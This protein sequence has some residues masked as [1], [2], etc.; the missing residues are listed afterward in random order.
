MR[1]LK[2][3][4]EAFEALLTTVFP[5]TCQV[6]GQLVET[7]AN[8]SACQQ[9]WAELVPLIPTESCRRCAYPLKLAAGYLPT[10]D[11]AFCRSL[12]F[13]CARACGRYEG[14]L[15]ASILQLKCQP[16]ICKKLVAMLAK[17]FDCE[18]A[19]QASE[20]I[21]PV[22]L[23]IERLRERGFNQAEIIGEKLSQIINRPIDAASLIRIKPTTKHRTGMDAIDRQKSVANAFTVE[24]PRLI[25]DA[26]I[27][28]V[29]DLFTTGSTLSAC[30]QTLI[31]AGATRVNV[32]TLARVVERVNHEG[33][34][35]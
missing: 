31:D 34:E 6:C 23:H 20:I 29:D 3:I 11:C 7:G 32:L 8:G 28:L 18:P 13:H 9:C 14:A 25:K 26:A 5:T 12:S 15:R 19:L 24:R 27:L 22:P 33:H 30:A 4:S 35:V 21:V 2:Q 16:Y 10:A 17:L 1:Q